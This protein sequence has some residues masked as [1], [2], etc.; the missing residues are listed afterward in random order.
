MTRTQLL[1]VSLAEECGETAQRA[2]KALRFGLDEKHA[3]NDQKGNDEGIVHEFND[4]VAVMQILHEEGALPR[5]VDR[6]LIKA[7]R[8]KLEHFLAYSK[9]R[10]ILD[11]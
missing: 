7:K 10:G 1:L 4:I 9:E 2:T 11:E 5:L 3:N 6:D 8:A